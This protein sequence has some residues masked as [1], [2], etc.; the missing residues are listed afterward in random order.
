MSGFLV[1]VCIGSCLVIFWQL[2][3]NYLVTVW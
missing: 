1:T 3:G 2:I